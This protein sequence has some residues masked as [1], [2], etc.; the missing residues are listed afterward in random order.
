MGQSKK[1]FMPKPIIGKDAPMPKIGGQ[2]I[3][4]STQ[5]TG[6]GIVVGQGLKTSGATFDSKKPIK[7]T[8]EIKGASKV[9]E[10]DKQTLSKLV[11]D[12]SEESKREEAKHFND[13]KAASMKKMQEI[14]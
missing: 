6:G 3:K 10:T 12:K 9:N 4:P 2:K 8:T 5:A 11:Q 1:P 13:S 7:V 14:Q